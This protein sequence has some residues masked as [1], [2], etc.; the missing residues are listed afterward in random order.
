MYRS[1][2]LKKMN[3]RLRNSTT[4]NLGRETLRSQVQPETT[5]NMRQIQTTRGSIT[6]SVS[7]RAG[8]KRNI[9]TSLLTTT[10]LPDLQP[11]VAP[12]SYLRWRYMNQRG[13]TQASFDKCQ[14]NLK[15]RAQAAMNSFQVQ[16]DQEDKRQKK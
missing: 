14:Q 15:D 1:E 5:T 10:R 13:A 7:R 16:L 3:L 2:T 4:A 12:E 11:A 9:D 6:F 8:T